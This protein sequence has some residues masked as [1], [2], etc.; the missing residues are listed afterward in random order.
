MMLSLRNRKEIWT[1]SHSVREKNGKLLGIP[2]LATLSA[3]HSGRARRTLRYLLA[4]MDV[5]ASKVWRFEVV[6]SVVGWQGM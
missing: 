6:F 3:R 1:L 5:Q 2:P 4:R